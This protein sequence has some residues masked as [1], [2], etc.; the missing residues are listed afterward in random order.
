MT[1]GRDRKE[2]SE[3]YGRSLVG[4]IHIETMRDCVGQYTFRDGGEETY[5]LR[6]QPFCR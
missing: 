4:R 6:R 5:Q 3:E 2:H 1:D